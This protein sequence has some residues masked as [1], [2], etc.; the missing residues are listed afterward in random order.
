MVIG[1][2]RVRGLPDR[3]RRIHEHLVALGFTYED[4]IPGELWDRI[5]VK[6]FDIACVPGSIRYATDTMA[7][8]DLVQRVPGGVRILTPN[9]TA[10]TPPRPPHAAHEDA[11]AAAPLSPAAARP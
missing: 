11:P 2:D 9:G 7:C 8:L 4:Y 3:A 5:V 6:A 10:A 1:S